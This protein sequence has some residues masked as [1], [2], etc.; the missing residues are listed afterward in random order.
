MLLEGSLQRLQHSRF[1]D[2]EALSQH[3]LLDSL[4]TNPSLLLCLFVSPLF[5]LSPQAF[6]KSKFVFSYLPP[7]ILSWPEAF[8]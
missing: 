1:D 5:L 6:L 8:R 7:S 2:L 3:R 4:V